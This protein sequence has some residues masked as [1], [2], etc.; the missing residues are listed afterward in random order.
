MCD[1]IDKEWA[2]ERTTRI[3]WMNGKQTVKGKWRIK[4]DSSETARSL[5]IVR[6][7]KNKGTVEEMLV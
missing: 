4:D 6:S 2:N 7:A 5:A 3:W 1:E